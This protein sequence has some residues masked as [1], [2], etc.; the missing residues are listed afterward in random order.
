MLRTAS[1]NARP[2]V[3]TTCDDN[4]LPDGDITAK[5]GARL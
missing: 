5:E 2:L 4:R 1:I 3:S